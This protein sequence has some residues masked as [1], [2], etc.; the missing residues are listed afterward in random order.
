MIWFDAPSAIWD[1][2]GSISLRIGYAADPPLPLLDAGAGYIL[3][4]HLAGNLTVSLGPSTHTLI[5]GSGLLFHAD[6]ARLAGHTSPVSGYALWFDRLPAP[7]AEGGGLSLGRPWH[8][9]GATRRS[10]EAHAS[11]LFEACSSL[12]AGALAVGHHVFAIMDRIVGGASPVDI[13][14]SPP[15]GF[16]AVL[17]YI[18]DHYTETGCTVAAICDRFYISQSTLC[19]RFKRYLHI[20]PFDYIESSRLEAARTRLL[21]GQSVQ[22]VC[23]TCGFSDCS[24]F[25]LRF[26]KR[27][28][29][30]PYRFCREYRLL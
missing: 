21:A 18:A 26:R 7:M 11:A 15:A 8:L 12:G 3:Y 19:R 5:A 6:V 27:Y 13:V 20:T 16:A 29:M 9:D 28:G 2:E 4:L 22:D 24:Y 14:P 30:T 1:C 17:A 25:I 23:Y 10:V